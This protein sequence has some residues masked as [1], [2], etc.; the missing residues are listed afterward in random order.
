M[1]DVMQAR[2]PHS[3]DGEPDMKEAAAA[4]LPPTR[5]VE[6]TLPRASRPPKPPQQH[7]NA[8]SAVEAP[9]MRP[10]LNLAIPS[11]SSESSCTTGASGSQDRSPTKHKSTRGTPHPVGRWGPTPWATAPPKSKCLSSE[12]FHPVLP[13]PVAMR[14]DRRGLTGATLYPTS[15]QHVSAPGCVQHLVYS[16]ARG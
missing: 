8:P 16:P 1:E 12:D 7:I 6:D 9:K 14:T 10:A 2:S 5:T 13:S 4:S 11:T 3:D 15:A